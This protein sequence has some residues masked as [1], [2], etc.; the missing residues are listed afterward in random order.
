MLDLALLCCC[1]VS[2]RFTCD[3]L[4]KSWAGLLEC[5]PSSDW[6]TV[7]PDGYSRILRSYVFGPSGFWTIALLRYA[8]KFDP[9]LSLDCAPTPSTLELPPTP[10]W[11]IP[12]KGRD[13]ILQSGNLAGGLLPRGVRRLQPLEHH[14]PPR[15][16][17]GLLSRLCPRHAQLQETGP[18][19][20][21]C[22]M[23]LKLTL[24]PI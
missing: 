14:R 21:N 16:R 1:L 23:I 17:G 18:G 9:F 20:G 11:R 7:L 2:Q 4:N 24:Y 6:F 5:L 19:T 13:Q 10:P 22:L 8:V 15:P 12:R 3:I